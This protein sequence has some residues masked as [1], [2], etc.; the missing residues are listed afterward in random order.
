MKLSY[1][2]SLILIAFA[3]IVLPGCVNMVF[4]GGQFVKNDNRIKQVLVRYKAESAVPPDTEYMLVQ[5]DKGLAVFEQY[6]K[7][8]GCLIETHWTDHDGDHFASWIY[9]AGGGNSMHGYE[10]IVPA[11]RTKN[12]LRYIYLSGTYLIQEINGIKRPVPVSRVE[13]VTTLIPINK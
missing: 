10:F 4:H 7:E 1:P 12:A 9:G 8:G 11:D 3:C 5:T 2:R 6:G 13:P